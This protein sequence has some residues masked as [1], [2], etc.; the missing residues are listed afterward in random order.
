MSQET[1]DVPL[2]QKMRLS[3][4]AAPSAAIERKELS[5]AQQQA[6]RERL[7]RLGDSANLVRELE[8]QLAAAADDRKRAKIEAQSSTARLE[9]IH[10]SLST[11]FECDTRKLNQVELGMA[12]SRSKSKLVTLADYIDRART[13]DDLVTIKRV[14]SNLG[15]TK[16]QTMAEAAALM[17]LSVRRAI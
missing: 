6:E 12:L 11:I 8:L 5:E 3:A 15:V 9:Q 4:Y 2:S 14:A 17:G 10:Q 13:L 7:S 1:Q 16:P